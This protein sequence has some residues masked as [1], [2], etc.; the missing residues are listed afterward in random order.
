MLVQGEWI[1]VGRAPA[2]SSP[3]RFGPKDVDDVNAW[4]SG[5]GRE[6]FR[7]HSTRQAVLAPHWRLCPHQDV[8][9][10][11]YCTLLS[12]LNAWAAFLPPDY[13]LYPF[14]RVCNSFDI[15]R[16]LRRP[17]ELPLVCAPRPYRHR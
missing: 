14:S 1:V 7:L 17:Q 11:L 3:A 12:V 16:L 2:G 15:P 8:T 13:C 9:W 6:Q 10:F 5:T 4:A